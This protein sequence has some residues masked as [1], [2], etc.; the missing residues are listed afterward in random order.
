MVVSFTN[1]FIFLRVPKNA[2]TTVSAHF[3]QNGCNPRFDTWTRIHEINAKDVNV[4]PAVFEN[5]NHDWHYVHLSLNEIIKCGVVTEE[6]AREMDVINIIREP[7]ER[8]LSLFFFRY[9]ESNPTV[10]SKTL[11]EEVIK[12]FFRKCFKDGYHYTDGS[13]KLRQ[14]D[15][16]TIGDE[17]VAECWLYENIDE[18]M[19]EFCSRKKIP[20]FPLDTFKSSERKEYDMSYY[21]DATY[22]AVAN[23]YAKDIELYNKLK[24]GTK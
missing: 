16:G 14:Y 18:H 19:R 5:H 2:S 6:Q 10:G 20:F 13:N 12:K 9:K 24:E 23:Y 8:Q 22:E 1:N 11:D 3:I 7:F 21:D 17:H 4:P 15:Y